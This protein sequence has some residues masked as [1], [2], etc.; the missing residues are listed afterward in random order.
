MLTN[1]ATQDGGG[2]F[3]ASSAD[4]HQRRGARQHGD[5]A[6]GNGGGIYAS[7]APSLTNVSILNNRAQIGGGLFVLAGS[8]L[9]GGLYQGNQATTAGGGIYAAGV[10]TLTT[11]PACSAIRPRGIGGGIYA[12]GSVSVTAP[13]WRAMPLIENGG[14]VYAPAGAAVTGGLFQANV[15]ANTAAADEGGG[16]GLYALAPVTMVDAQFVG[17]SVSGQGGGGGAYISATLTLTNVQF[18]SNTVAPHQHDGRRRR[19]CRGR[20]DRLPAASSRATPAPVMAARAAALFTSGT[21]TMTGASVRG[22]RGGGCWRRRG[23]HGRRRT[24]SGGI[25]Q[26]NRSTTNGGGGVASTTGA[27][28]LTNVDCA[29]QYGA[30][31]R[32]RRL[33]A[34]G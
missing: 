25:I 15:A 17:N 9:S 32:R 34:V 5:L 11:A 26:G 33:R 30:E 4:A 16:G 27:L 1:T 23:C 14:G 20:H 2:I 24:I 10:L 3:A 6:S 29:E 19:L 18:M 12:M 31:Q 28:T 13:R 7:T 8:A 22:Q 21:L